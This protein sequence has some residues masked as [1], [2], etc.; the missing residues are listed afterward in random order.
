MTVLSDTME[1]YIRAIYLLETQSGEWVST[2]ALAD[3]LDR[4]PPSVTSMV[5][6][7]EEKGFVDREEYEGVT[8]TKE[9]EVVALEIIRHHRLLEQFLVDYLDFDWSE[10]HEEA[11]RLEHHISERLEERMADALGNPAADPHGDPIPDPDLELPECGET[12]R[13]DE[14]ALESDVV[15]S[16]IHHQGEEELR[17]LGDLGIQPGATVQLIEIAPFGMLTVGTADGEETIP[18]TV[19]HLIEVVPKSDVKAAE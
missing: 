12:A 18:Q 11:D 10:V 15:V 17:F 4:A 14:V 1:D 16:R 5:Q 6:K 3:R 8:L 7:L 13:L 9:G 19:G 2:S